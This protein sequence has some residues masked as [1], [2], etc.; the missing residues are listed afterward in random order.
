MQERGEPTR[1]DLKEFKYYAD[2]VDFAR[3]KDWSVTETI[4]Q[5]HENGFDL[6]E[7]GNVL[8]EAGV[9]I[10][11]T[12]KGLDS[13]GLDWTQIAEVLKAM[14]CASKEIINAMSHLGHDVSEIAY[15]LE[16]SENNTPETIAL[17]EKMQDDFLANGIIEKL[18]EVHEAREQQG[19]RFQPR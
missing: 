7:T 19:L 13:V 1:Q 2:I 10:E 9:S 15:V 17:L 3:G 16:F 12:L 11:D 5:L 18:K 8:K 4:K 6:V 14:K